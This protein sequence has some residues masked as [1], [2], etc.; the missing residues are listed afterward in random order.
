MDAIVT[1]L[2]WNRDGS[3]CQNALSLSKEWLVTNG[4]GGYASGTIG[5]APTRRYHGLLIAALPAPYGRMVMLN[6]L[7][8]QIILTAGKTVRIGSEDSAEEMS[9]QPGAHC[10]VEFRLES[11]IP[12]WKYD[13]EGIVFEKQLHLLYMQNT[14]HVTYRMISGPASVRLE[15]RPSMHFRSHETA[16]NSTLH[17]PYTLLALGDRYE[18]FYPVSRDLRPLRMK[19]Y[20]ER[21]AFTSDGGSFREL[22]YRKEA[23]RGYDSLGAVWNPGYFRGELSAG[24]SATLIA[25]TEPWATIL[26]L[27]PED[28]LLYETG[29]R[30]RLIETADP[31]ARSGLAADLVIAADQF[32]ITPTSR[33]EDAARARAAG[34]E[35]RTIIAGYHWFTDWGRDTMISLEGLTL[36]TGRHSE[37]G[38]ILR[39]FAHYIK[40]G[41]LPNMFPEGQREGKYHTADATLWF[42]HA[43]DR[44][45]KATGDRK[46]LRQI[47]PRLVAIIDRH[48][49]GTHFGIKA[50]MEDG[51]LVQGKEGFQLTWMDAKVEDWVVTPR[52]GKAVEI[53]S[54]WYNAL[55]LLEGWILEESKDAGAEKYSSL[56]LKAYE[57]FNRKFWCERRGYLYD[58][59]DGDRGNDDSLRPNQVMAISLRHPVLE[60][61]R[62]PQVLGKVQE[63]LLTPMGLRSLA[64]GHPDYKAKYFGDLR[65]R[66]AAYHQGT[67]W[68]WLIGHFIDAWLKEFPDD[69]ERAK[70][71]LDGFK[72]HLSEACIGTI[73]E[74]FDGDAPFT[75]RGC[76]AQAWSVAEV[77]RCLVNL[78]GDGK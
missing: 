13:A 1:K 73:S 55:K 70:G 18:I 49:E 27:K 8:E 51:L 58:V 9:E 19:F 3:S 75:P 54:L 12:V 11:G 64:P 28:A 33:I 4:L 77:L 62:W 44:Y 74:I 68:A 42:F 16:V 66:D 53:N 56:A 30:R 29:R 38:W 37:A 65:A 41:L 20:N 60:R 32:I 67:V 14:V 59:I 46:T 47:L 21:A 22:F 17:E 2:L 52:R 72:P 25:S 45:V 76:I 6:H 71:F 15:I 63:S 24:R 57:S 26:A 7:D 61:K 5:G 34:D 36:V 40:D 50:D 23:E 35:I 31:A 43:V 78:S 48:I 10:L 39:T 69:R